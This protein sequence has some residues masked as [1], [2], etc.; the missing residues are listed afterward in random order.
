MIIP[1]ARAEFRR[2]VARTASLPP[3]VGGWNARDSLAAMKPTDAVQLDNYVPGTENVYLRGG[4]TR[5]AQ[6]VGQLSAFTRAST[7]TYM[8]QGVFDTVTGTLMTADVDEPRYRTVAAVAGTSESTDLV[9]ESAATNRVLW[10]RDITN[11]AW[12][13]SNVTAAKT[14]TGI[15]GVANSATEITGTGSNARITQSITDASKARIVS[16]YVKLISGTGNFAITLNDFSSSTS[17]SLSTA[18]GWT[19]LSRT[20][21]LAN[22]VIGLQIDNGSVWHV[23]FVQEEDGSSATSPIPT[24]TATVTRAA[25]TPTYTTG[26]SASVTGPDIET[27]ISYAGPT[28]SKLLAC[29]GGCIYD[30]T[31]AGPAGVPL[32]TGFSTDRWQYVNMNGNALLFNGADTPQKYDGSAIS[33]NSIT[34]VTSS[35]LIYPNVHKHRL[36]MVEKNTMKVWY[37][38]T[39]AISGAATALDF[40]SY[41]KLGG[42]MVAMG[43]WT[44]D[45]GDG[46]DDLAV[47]ITSKGE[48][49]VFQ[50]TDPADADNWA[51]VGVFRI[52]API[53]N[54]PLVKMAGDLVVISEDGFVPLSQ[55]ISLDRTGAKQ[56][57]ISDKI[58]KAVSDATKLYKSNF[59]WEGNFYPRGNWGIFNIPLVEGSTFHQ[60]VINTLN[61][62]WCRFKG[63]NGRCFEVFAERLY[64]GA[65]NGMVMLAD[66][67]YADVSTSTVLF[68]DIVG[69]IKPAFQYFSS[70]S[71]K[72]Q[73]KA[74]RPVI[75]SDA[76]ISIAMAICVDFE[77]KNPVTVSTAAVTGAVWDASPWDTTAWQTGNIIRKNWITANG[78]GYCA[79]AHLRTSTSGI[80]IALNSIDWLYEPGGVM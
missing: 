54:R 38:A 72:K 35:N 22:P 51:L 57:A 11:A 53:G 78:N 41:C 68:N 31:D 26:S 5:H 19:R 30:A 67:G 47:F 79:S 2:Q 75:S 61:G 8:S 7:A 64:F 1:A 33:S 44:R 60:Y 37:L 9:I 59:G 66:E 10:N 48:A 21:T 13:K 58:R 6:N 73:F 77:D 14:A 3:P 76:A 28:S 56:R 4:S 27:L 45:G 65:G 74:V 71:Q 12:T 70:R 25:D 36:F 16:I 17:G 39:D 29:A 46:M 23:D 63:W 32:A 15:D 20:G 24:T 42:R 49:L 52:G 80:A 69:D 62:S 40:S 18:N 43:T 55:V 50:G 34:G